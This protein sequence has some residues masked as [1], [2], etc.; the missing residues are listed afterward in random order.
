LLAQICVTVLLAGCGPAPA[1]APAPD[2][3][4]TK[5]SKVD[6]V[7][8]V[9]QENRSVDNLF[10]GLP[11]A[12]TVRYGKAKR[13]RT[14]RLRPVSLVAPYDLSHRHRAFELEYD[15]GLLD[16]FNR[17]RSDCT[18]KQKCPPKKFRA[19]GYV[20]QSEVQ[21]Y[22]TMAERY[23]FGDR[24]FQSNQGPSFP[25]H[26]YLLSGTSTIE[27]HSL[28]RAAENPERPGGGF[29]GGCNSPPGSFVEVIDPQ[30]QEDQKV[31]PCFKR[32]S[33]IDLLEEKALSWRYYGHHKYAGLWNAP[34]AIQHIRDSAEYHYDVVTPPTAILRDLARGELA[35]VTWVTPTVKASD[36]PGGTDGTGPAWVASVVNAIGESKF[37][38]DTVI[39][40]V[41]DDWGGWYD[42]VPPP[43][44]NS[45]ELGFRVPLIVISPYAKRG[46][47]SHRQYEFGSIL[48]FVEE[49][50][51]L[52]SLGTTDVRASDLGD[53]FNY[54]AP[55]RRF[56]RIPV[57][58]SE[59]YFLTQPPDDG[60]VDSDF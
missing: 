8:I 36:H 22:F 29:T 32:I 37:W 16:G 54:R 20:P 25:A 39:L 30:G 14:F 13:G 18:P 11:G 1:V 2:P 10:N 19:Y 6:H 34:D 57:P 3:V 17:E 41:W 38:D 50:F 55:P 9:I 47:V 52:G 43:I 21:P 46:Y 44:Y 33:L 7:V 53:F 60:D 51:N 58:L 27:Q 42:H 56:V 4:A 24:M 28:L 40:V 48:K 5:S 15:D 35:T 23:G 45:Y 49:T 59:S 26:Q 31:Y 12:D